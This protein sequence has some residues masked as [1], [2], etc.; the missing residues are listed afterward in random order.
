M[1]IC[2]MICEGTIPSFAWGDQTKPR[3]YLGRIA[4]IPAE[5]RTEVIQN[6]SLRR[7]AY[8]NPLAYEVLMRY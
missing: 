3:K 6:T 1:V 4:G 5:C 8:D 2:C 7:Y